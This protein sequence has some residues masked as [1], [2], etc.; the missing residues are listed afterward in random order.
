[1]NQFYA[2][3]ADIVALGVIG[4][5]IFRCTGSDISRAVDDIMNAK[6]GISVKKLLPTRCIAR[7]TRID[8][9]AVN[10]KWT[11]D[12]VYDDSVNFSPQRARRCG[13][14]FGVAGKLDTKRRCYVPK[15]RPSALHKLESR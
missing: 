6:N 4:D 15:A 14:G 12:R 3:R 9:M 8:N 1:M 13:A 11:A 5:S 7:R 2:D 10:T